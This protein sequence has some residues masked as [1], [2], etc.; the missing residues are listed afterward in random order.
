MPTEHYIVDSPEEVVRETTSYAS[1]LDYM[2]E[3]VALCDAGLVVQQANPAFAALLG[4]PRPEL[5]GQILTELPGTWREE[6]GSVLKPERYAAAVALRTGRPVRDQ[7]VH[8]QTPDGDLRW[9]STNAQPVPSDADGRAVVLTVRDVTEHRYSSEQHD[10]WRGL[11]QEA[12]W[13]RAH[14][15]AVQAPQPLPASPE[16][17]PPRL[18]EHHR[19]RVTALRATGLLD[20][21]PEHAFDRLTALVCE[22]LGVPVSLVSLVD[23]DRQFF[24]SAQGLGEPWASTRETPLSHSFCQHV[25]ASSQPLIIPDARAH[26]LVCDNLAVGELGV[27]AYLG[28]PLFT[29]DGV[30]IGSLCA[31]D[32]ETRTWTDQQVQVLSAL[33]DSAMT[34]IA[35]RLH[36]RER[37]DALAELRAINE[38]LEARVR[39]RT[40]ELSRL[41]KELTK[42]NQELQHF[43]Y[44]ASHDLQEPLRKITAFAGLTLEDYGELLDDQ[45]RYYLERM[46]NAARR[47][48]QL[49]RDLLQ[50]SRVITHGQPFQPVDL[51]VLVAESVSDLDLSA[52]E[53]EADI[54]VSNLPTIEADPGQ[55]QRLL[56]NLLTNAL[57]FHRPGV[58]PRIEITAEVESYGALPDVCRIEVRDNGLGFEEKFSERIFMPFERLHARGKYE[59]TGMG[60]AVCRRIA[61]RHGGSI[62]ARSQ[63]GEGSSFIVRL[64][65]RQPHAAEALG[66]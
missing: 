28:V 25:A 32:H 65:V 1:L 31:I 60:L 6:D 64:P 19:R 58:P 23:E 9:L 10:Q 33:A 17:A 42:R 24:K 36:L 63:P 59:G 51:Q 16:T 7:V 21:P 34:E 49:L 18:A 22:I 57:K 44:I 41:N 40:G 4:V 12:G 37:D 14:V 26:G 55:I 52:A 2:A 62:V 53:A 66:R 13:G 50:Y 56:R 47:M 38:T 29:P 30:A 8:Y 54:K 48:A 46:E 20:T 61:E 27:V 3:G 11:F 35:V 15:G 5:H 45:G 43:A 39:E